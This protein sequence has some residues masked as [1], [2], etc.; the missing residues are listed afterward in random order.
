MRRLN[1]KADRN[2]V[3]TVEDFEQMVTGDATELTLGP[4]PRLQFDAL[5]TS[6]AF[7]AND[8]G[9]SRN[10]TVSPCL[11][12]FHRVPLDLSADNLA[13]K[14]NLPFRTGSGPRN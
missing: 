5:V 10:G 7:W 12:K 4:R 14:L 8:I 9:F 2:L 13:L 11:A 3:R 6:A 1:G